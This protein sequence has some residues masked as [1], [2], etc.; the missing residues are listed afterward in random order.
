MIVLDIKVVSE[1]M[2]LGPHPSMR[3]WL[4][5]QVAETQYLSSVTVAGLLPGIGRFQP[6]SVETC[7]YRP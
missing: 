3:T 1:T 7:W 5:D 4:K 6:A 2:K